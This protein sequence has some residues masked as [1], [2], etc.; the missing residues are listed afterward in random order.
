MP[1]TPRRPAA[2]VLGC[3]S[4]GR[5]SRDTTAVF[6]PSRT[7]ARQA[8]HSRSPFHEVE[9]CPR[10]RIRPSS[11]EKGPELSLCRR[12]RVDGFGRNPESDLRTHA[13]LAPDLKLTTDQ[14]GA[15]SHP[16]QSKV[17][18]SMTVQHCRVDPQ[19]VI[20]DEKL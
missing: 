15:L 11:S 9:R 7:P 5:S 12:S 17:A 6:G 20:T 14:L 2:W 19:A 3:L 4:A 10:L 13:S 8:R 18:V 1:S 16:R